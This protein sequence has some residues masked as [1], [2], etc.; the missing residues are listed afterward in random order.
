MDPVLAPTQIHSPVAMDLWW[1]GPDL[2][3]THPYG[4]PCPW[5][6]GG[7]PRL[8][9]RPGRRTRRRA[10]AVLHQPH[11]LAHRPS[12]AAFFHGATHGGG[13]GH[14]AALAAA[15]AATLGTSVAG[16]GHGAALAAAQAAALGTPMAGVG[17][18]P[19]MDNELPAWFQGKA[20]TTFGA[21][22]MSKGSSHV[23]ATPSTTVGEHRTF[24]ATSTRR[25]GGRA[26]RP[27]P[28]ATRSLD[29]TLTDN[30]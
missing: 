8:C 10:R 16:A 15:Q 9:R 19:P 12:M 28:V 2:V 20:T 23:A 27:P 21:D 5:R 14:D 11:I 25:K 18:G 6:A 17:H 26:P 7:W 30:R 4:R 24:E 3:G 1:L 29:V 13:P 22:W